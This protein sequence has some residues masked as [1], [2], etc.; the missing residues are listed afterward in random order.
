[1]KGKVLKSA[2]FSF[3][4]QLVASLSFA[5]TPPQFANLTSCQLSADTAVLTSTCADVAAANLPR[6]ELFDGTDATK[7]DGAFGAQLFRVTLP[8]TLT[9]NAATSM[10]PDYA[11]V[12][13]WN[14]DGTRL[15][16]YSNNGFIHLLDGNTYAYIEELTS[17]K[18][19]QYGGQDLEPRWSHT[20]P[21]VFYYVVGMKLNAYD[22]STH[23][24]TT[25]HWFTD[26]EIGCTGCANIH[27]GD[28]GNSDD[29]DRYWAFYAQLGAPSYAQQVIFSYD[30]ETNAVVASKSLTGSDFCGSAPCPTKLNWVGM[31]HSGAQL[32]AQWQL[33]QT[34]G[35]MTTRGKGTESFDRNLNY[36][37]KISEKN[38]HADLAQTADGKDVYVGSS[39]LNLRNGYRAIR[40][41]DLNNGAILKSCMLPQSQYNH[42]SGR[43]D[44]SLLKGWVLYSTYDQTGQG[45]GIDIPGGI[46]AVEN[47]ALNIDTCEVRRIVHNQSNW[48]YSNYFSEPHASMNGDFTKIIWGSNW[49]VKSDKVQA[50]VT[51]LPQVAVPVTVPEVALTSPAPNTTV[52]GTVTVTASATDPSGIKRVEFYLDGV[53]DS[54]RSTAPYSYDWNTTILPNGPYTISAK[55]YDNAGTVGQSTVLAVVVNNPQPD[56]TAPSVSLT[57]PVNN[58]MVGGTTLISAEASDDT[59]VTRVDYFLNGALRASSNTPPYTFAWSTK[60]EVN[61]DFAIM[62][63]AYDAAGNVGQST[64]VVVEVL[65]DTTAPVVSIISPVTRSSVAGLVAVLASASDNVAVTRV[66]FYVDGTLKATS[67]S[68]PYSFTWNTETLTNSAYTLTAKAYDSAGNVASAGIPINVFYDGSAPTI[69]TFSMPT[70]KNSTIVPVLGLLATDNVA[71]TSYLITESATVPSASAAGWSAVPPTSFTFAGTG[72]R[73]AYAWAKDGAGHVSAASSATVLI[74]T[75]LPVIKSLSLASGSSSV[76]IKAAATDNIGVTKMELYVDGALQL[77]AAADNFT[78]VWI[79]GLKKSQSITVKVYDAAGN[80]R[81]QSFR[82]SKI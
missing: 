34:D 67:T 72:L 18:G 37:A 23:S 2:A 26:S 70:T 42:V 30:T 13:A 60:A 43:T 16:V 22:I 44:G 32:M 53:L 76:T 52:T 71:V 69:T 40:V 78:F 21:N 59:A 35:D 82:V 38:W 10:Y 51:E 7:Q 9:D 4:V 25:V 5:A 15:M 79:A 63:Q 24:T 49:R 47:F 66:E 73:T 54:T 33:P 19:L 29:T 27:N 36:L 57:S 6:P 28:E 68:A 31:S 55:A 64:S 17:A 41:V 80:V 12:Q 20:D 81:S 65:N 46:L 14:S 58:S 1:M 11:K 8:A 77:Q 56:R 75:F 48:S 74:D 39:R 62:A 61:G 50:Y 3:F 45:K